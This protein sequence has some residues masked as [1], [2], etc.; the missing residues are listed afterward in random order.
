ME[1]VVR[2]GDVDDTDD[3]REILRLQLNILGY[4]MVEATNGQEAMEILSEESPELILMHAGA[5]WHR[6]DTLD[7]QNC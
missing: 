6:G 5:W 2:V 1:R 4:R 3:V 7:S